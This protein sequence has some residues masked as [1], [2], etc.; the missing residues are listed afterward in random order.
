M[1]CY[2]SWLVLG[3]V[4][5][6]RLERVP[7][8]GGGAATFCESPECNGCPGLVGASSPLRARG[9]ATLTSQVLLGAIGAV[10]SCRTF[11]AHPPALVCWSSVTHVHGPLCRVPLRALP[12]PLSLSGRRVRSVERSSPCVFVWLL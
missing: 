2:V 6:V 10:P 12:E 11:R 9:P 3:I 5:R 1:L 7:S 8:P 4:S